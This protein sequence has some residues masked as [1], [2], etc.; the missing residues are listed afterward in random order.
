MANEANRGPMFGDLVTGR[1]SGRRRWMM[2]CLGNTY[3]KLPNGREKRGGS[4][5]KGTR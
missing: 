3:K 2:D 4:R 5:T 1:A